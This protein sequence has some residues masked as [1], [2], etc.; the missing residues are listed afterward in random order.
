[1]TKSTGFISGRGRDREIWGR[2]AKRNGGFEE[3]RA[4]GHEGRR[5]RGREDTRA[6]GQGKG[7]G[8]ITEC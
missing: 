1:M 5:T 7:K 3:W 6:G 4:G 2:D 8:K